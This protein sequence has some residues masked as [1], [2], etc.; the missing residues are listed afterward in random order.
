MWEEAAG[1]LRTAWRL[2]GGV[3]GGGVLSVGREEGWGRSNTH[4]YNTHTHAHIHM[5]RARVS[6]NLGVVLDEL[7][8]V[9]C[10]SF[11]WVE[12]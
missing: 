3:S 10:D 6:Q 4:T 2:L 12:T 7:G 1:L 11:V 5:A 8:A 9:Y